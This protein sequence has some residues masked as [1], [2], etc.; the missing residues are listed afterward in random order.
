AAGCVLFMALCGRA[1]FEGTSALE[2]IRGHLERTPPDVRTLRLDVSP[3]LAGVVR[4]LLEKERDR[5]PR[6][7]AEALRLLDDAAPPGGASRLD[8]T[9]APRA[10]P[11]TLPDG[12]SPRAVPLTLPDGATPRAF[13]G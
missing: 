12:A 10:F 11:S 1:P 4:R 6:D 2:I 13:P 9:A 7:P 5:R 8:D 3:A